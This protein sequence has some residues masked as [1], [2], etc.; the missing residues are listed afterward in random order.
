MTDVV[1]LAER[2]WENSDDPKAHRPSD[3]LRLTADRIDRGEIVVEHA[4]V[5]LGA[6][7][8][9]RTMRVRYLQAGTYNHFGQVGLLTSATN[10]LDA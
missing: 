5:V 2:R 10:M 1:S 8:E 9:D 4:I 3:M 7:E 6:S